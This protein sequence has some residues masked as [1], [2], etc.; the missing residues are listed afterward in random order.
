MVTQH[1]HSTG[2]SGICRMMKTIGKKPR[3]KYHESDSHANS[4]VGQRSGNGGL[5]AE[6]AS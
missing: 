1:N 3:A 2:K 5:G 4:N 6:Q